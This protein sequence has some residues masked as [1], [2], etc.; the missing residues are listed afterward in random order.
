MPRLAIVGAGP[1]GLAAAWALR[2][3][4]IQVVLFEKSRVVSGRAATRRRD[5][6]VY[7]FGANYFKT[8]TDRLRALVHETLP[9][10]DLVRIE[11]GV[12]AFDGRG[13]VVPGDPEHNAEPRW[14]YRTGIR[15]LGVHLAEAARAEVRRQT[16]VGRLVRDADAWRLADDGGRDL[17]AFD[18]VLL[19]PPAPQAADLL[20]HSRFDDAVRTVLVRA[21]RGVPFRSQFAFVFGL[22]ERV[23][24]PEAAYAL[25]NTDG[26]HPVAWLGFEHAKPGR[27]PEGASVLVAQMAPDWTRARYDHDPD[28][29]QREAFG[30]VRGLLG[31]PLPEPAWWDHQRWRYALPD[32]PLDGAALAGGASLGL[33]VAGDAVAGAGRVQRALDA[34]LDVAPR[35]AQYLSRRG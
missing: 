28:E 23:A 8:D 11:A 14:T 29:L 13:K 26:A 5:G 2:D 20:E 12:A 35:L 31:R 34:G 17:G 15:T 9:T 22:A 32:A 18:A 7:D 6:L 16:R 24:A 30:L 21:L 1:A 25:L 33:F 4:P 3:A 19:T 10:D 27:V